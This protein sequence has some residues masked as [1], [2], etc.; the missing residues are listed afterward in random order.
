MPV[1]RMQ[2]DVQN[3]GY[4][5]GLTAAHAA[6]A[7]VDLRDLEIRRIQKELVKIGMLDEGVLELQD[8]PPPSDEELAAAVPR[9]VDGFSGI[10]TVLAAPERAM[11]RLIEAFQSS[12]GREARLIYAQILGLLGDATGLEDLIDHLYSLE[13]DDGWD[14]VGMGQFG[15]SMSP[16]DDIILALG[17]IGDSRGLPPVL[18]KMRQ[19]DPA[20]GFSHFRAVAMAAERIGDPRAAADLARLLR[21]EGVQGHAFDQVE[22]EISLTPGSSTDNTTRNLALRELLLARAL[23]RCGD[24]EGLAERVLRTYCQ[25]LRGP[26]SRHAEAVL[27]RGPG[28]VPLIPVE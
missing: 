23:Y 27:A 10:H 4:A 8:S 24:E 6:L 19:L 11:P 28:A 7:G 20:H 16:V 14:Y 2:P 13:W 3:Q 26:F 22:R 12:P 17:T 9:V 18:E 5:A 21:L 25:D 15:R 1:I